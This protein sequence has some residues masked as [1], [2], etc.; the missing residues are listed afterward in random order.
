MQSCSLYKIKLVSDFPG[1][2]LPIGT[3]IDLGK[4]KE[5]WEYL[6]KRYPNIYQ[7]ALWHH[8][9]T[10]LSILPKYL[11]DIVND[12]IQTVYIVDEYFISDENNF[13]EKKEICFKS[14]LV[15]LD[16]SF[17]RRIDFL[18]PATEEEYLEYKQKFI[19]Q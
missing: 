17:E 13:E 5:K 6:G 8:G 3:I 1:N 12:K 14:K 15:Y 18:I 19:K 7:R 16:G 11:K 10:D 2:V 4:D 9:I